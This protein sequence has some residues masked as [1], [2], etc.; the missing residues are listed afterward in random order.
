[1]HEDDDGGGLLLGFEVVVE[2]DG[3]DQDLLEMDLGRRAVLRLVIDD[4][5][6]VIPELALHDAAGL[7][8]PEREGGGFDFR[9]QETAADDA[10]IAFVG[11]HGRILAVG[12][13]DVLEVLAGL[14]LR[15]GRFGLLALLDVQRVVFADGLFEFLSDEERVQ[16]ARLEL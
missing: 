3:A 13:R 4:P 14:E 6:D 7:A 11:G 16:D 8:V 15:E 5:Q 1:M 10:T 9:R 2:L 12:E